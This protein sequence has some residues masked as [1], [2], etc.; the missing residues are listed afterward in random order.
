MTMKGIDVSSYQTAA[1]AGM[2]GI[3]FTIIKAT[4][5]RSYVNPLCNAQWDA[6]GKAGHL[7]GLYHYASGG[8]PAKEADYFIAQIK[9]YVGKGILALDWEAGQNAAW[10]SKSW[11]LTFVKRIHSKTGVWPVIYVQA[12]A[13]AQVASCAPYCGLWIAGYPTNAASWTVPSFIYSTGAWKSAT[14]W[15]FSSG[16]SLDRNVAYV[17]AAG[18]NAIAK[19]SKVKTAAAKVTT[20]V[21]IVAKK[22]TYSTKKKTVWRM[23][24]DTVAGKTGNGKTRVKTL[25]KYYTGVQAAANYL[26]KSTSK[27]TAMK[28]LAA[29]TKKGVFG[30]GSTRKAILGTWYDEVQAIINGATMAAPAARTYTVKSGDTLSGIGSKLGVA[31]ATL[32]TKNDIKSPYTIYP[33]Q[34]LKY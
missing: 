29:E 11:A 2:S 20:A 7:R 12:S 17:S 5:G 33:G 26:M 31:W 13:I 15:Q 34:K 21:K 3:D 1:Q 10:G 25:G 8:D 18:W 28:A 9:N 16:G 14:I 32:A 6:A 27:A 24:T 23:A 4:Q 19:A 22:A 30:T